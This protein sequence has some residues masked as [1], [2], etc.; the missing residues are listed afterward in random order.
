MPSGFFGSAVVLGIGVVF[1]SDAPEA[2]KAA[3]EVFPKC[4]ACGTGVPAPAVYIVLV[5]N[6]AHDTPIEEHRIRGKQLHIVRDGVTIEADGERGHAN[7][8]F[9]V[10]VIGSGLFRDAISTAALFLVAQRDR[11]PVHASAIMFD[12]RAY[13]LAGRSGSGKSTLALAATRFGLPVLAEDTVFIQLAPSFRVWGL[14]DR[15]HV[16]EKDA[17]PGADGQMRF[18]SGRLKRALPIADVRQSADKAALCVIAR[19][20]HAVLD[21]LPLEDAVRTLSRAPEPGYD[22]SG[23]LMED[24]IRAIAI[25]GCWKLSLSHNPDAAI[26]ALLDA[27]S[28]PAQHSSVV[29]HGDV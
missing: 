16:F 21:P 11:I 23:M 2:L 1:E 14:A 19:G 26:A 15:I 25:G 3:L 27:F 5:A 4:H 29:E 9:C 22:V 8:S 12:D 18:R 6:H 10:D 13:V 24:A 17:P 28:N 20:E 7:C